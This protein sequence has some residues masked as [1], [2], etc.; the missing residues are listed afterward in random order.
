MSRIK[1]RSKRRM[2]G[3]VVAVAS[4]LSVT[5][6]GSASGGGGPE[7]SDDLPD[8]IKVVAINVETGAAAFAGLAAN[9][10]YELA[11]KEINESDFLDGS[12]LEVDF[13]D[14]KGEPQTAAQELTKAT[15]SGDVTAVFGSVLSSDAVAMSPLA[16]KAKMPIIYTQAGSDGVVIGDYTYRMTPL[17]R[18]YYVNLKKYIA[19]TG[20]KSIGIIY[21]EATPTLQDIGKTVLPAMAKELGIEVTTSIGTPATTQDFAAPI[22]QV[23][24]SKPDLVS[25]LLVGAANPTAMTQLRQAGYDGPVIGNSGA[26]AGN[27]EPAGDAGYG[28]V[29][30]SDFNYQTTNE[31]SQKF[32]K[33]YNDE[34]GEDPLNYAAEA[35]DAAWFLATSLKEAQ[36]AD[37]ESVKDA[38]ATV[39][40]EPFDGALGEGLTFDEQ[41]VVVPGC[42]VE[43]SAEGENLLY[44]GTGE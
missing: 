32:V 6:C 23:L 16:E 37:H 14:S 39:A 8:T 19:D 38:M 40:A 30:A 1:G 15:T 11:V 4:V 25:V 35:Y 7:A 3:L 18:S 42:V 34:Y 33:L 2:A 27:L 43:Y 5:A 12:K 20:A 13:A 10:G 26:S 29:W 22:S 36:S 28:M 24:D 21:T 31:S 41:T 17:M 9:K 44:E